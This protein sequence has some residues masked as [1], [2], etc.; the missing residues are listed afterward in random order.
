M[1]VRSAMLHA[2]LMIVLMPACLFQAAPGLAQN[3]PPEDGSQAAT[4]EKPVDIPVFR[5]TTTL[6]YLDV[7]VVD[8]KGRPV[9]TGLSSNDFTITEDKRPQH[10][11]SFEE[12]DVHGLSGPDSKGDHSA[13]AVAEG[14]AP[15]TILL[16]DLL[17]TQFQDFAFVRDQTRK[18]LMMQPEELAAPAEMLVLGN[19]A[20]EVLLKPTRSRQELLAALDHLPRAIPYK[21]VYKTN[22]SDELIRQSYD[23]LQQIAIQNRGMPGRK[24]VIWIGMGPPSINNRQLADALIEV[25]QQY[26]R[27]TVNLLVESRITLFQIYP[28]FHP[29]GTGIETKAQS[30]GLITGSETG[31][32]STPFEGGDQRFTEFVHETG[33]ELFNQNDVSVM[34]QKSVDLGSKYYTLTYQPQGGEADGRFRRIEVKLRNSDLRVVTKAG[35]FGREKGELADSDN[36]TVDMLRDASLATVPFPALDVRIAGVVRHPDT[37]TAEITLKLDDRKLHWQTAEDGKSSTTVIVTAV[38]RSGRE[39]V[40]ASR[41]AKFY[42]LASSQDTDRLAGAKPEVKMTLPVPRDTKN[43]RLALATEGG[44][45]IGSVD[46]DRKTIDAAP[47]A[48]TPDPGLLRVRAKTSKVEQ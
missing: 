11:F 38:S 21:A 1:W 25:V 22:F 44:E 33:G 16:L 36:R 12:P 19:S 31:N 7:T 29:V 45:R 41:V 3:G 32:A 15:E 48:V 39:Q 47:V 30:E 26:V 23:A 34:I 37:H 2:S 18:F 42:L 9:E 20:L 24:N 43:V 17:N 27:H 8:K 5:S 4:K 14:K 46:V 28:G 10:I 40:L 6:V 35:Y 13:E